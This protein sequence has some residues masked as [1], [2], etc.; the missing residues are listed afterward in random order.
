M[1][2]EPSKTSAYTDIALGAAKE[3]V[4]WAVG[5]KQ[6][7]AEGLARKEKGNAELE[8]AK[9]EQRA[10]GTKDQVK[11]NIK[12]AAGNVLGNEQWQAEGKADQLKGDARKA[13]NQ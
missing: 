13:V 6:M 4:G 7:E 1:S 11:G 2:A 9:A 3:N 8:A 12:E 10:I 5:N